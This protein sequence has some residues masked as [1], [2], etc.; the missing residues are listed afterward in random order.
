[1]TAPA[2][3]T[4]TELLTLLER[5][6][7][8]ALEDAVRGLSRGTLPHYTASR[9][10][11]NLERLARLYDLAT[12]CVES[13]SLLPMTA[14]AREVARERY[15]DGFDLDEV[16][17][18]FNVLE[19]ILWR[20]ITARLEPPQFPHALGLVSTVLGAGKQALALEYVALASRNRDVQSLDL[21]ALFKGTT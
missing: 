7:A 6:R 5:S 15:R 11:Q 20:E 13:C 3:V 14:Y 16:H 10:E 12:A 9:A 18:A 19:E 21:T 1:M 17:A 2:A 4:S 8:Q